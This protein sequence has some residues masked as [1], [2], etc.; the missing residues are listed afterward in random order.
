MKHSSRRNILM[1]GLAALGAGL[2]AMIPEARAAVAASRR[3]DVPWYAVKPVEQI[4]LEGAE[5]KAA[6]LRLIGRAD[7]QGLLPL[8]RSARPEDQLAAVTGEDKAFAARNL[9]EDKA[10]AARNLLPDGR[11]MTSYGVLLNDGRALG[12]YVAEGGPARSEL[13]LYAPSRTDADTF[14]L[15]RAVRNGAPLDL[16]AGFPPVCCELNRGQFATCCGGCFFV[17]ATPPATLCVPCVLAY[18]AACYVVNCNRW[19]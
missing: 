14:T 19:C 9:L 12:A 3:Q 18:C 13:L 17:C 16:A 7:V 5:R 2:V 4:K 8:P 15:D 10:F 6:L 1:R 11:W